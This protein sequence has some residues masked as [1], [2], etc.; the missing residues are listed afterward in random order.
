MFAHPECDYFL[1]AVKYTSRVTPNGMPSVS[2]SMSPSRVLQ[3]HPAVL[4]LGSQA[5]PR[6]VNRLE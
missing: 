3:T 2:Q 1:T 4:V 6:M 5:F